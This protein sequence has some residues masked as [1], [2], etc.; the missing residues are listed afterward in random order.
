[1][2][3]SPSSRKGPV[4]KNSGRESSQKLVLPWKILVPTMNSVA[5]QTKAAKQTLNMLT[6]VPTIMP[7][8]EIAPLRNSVKRVN[9]IP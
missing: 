1:M 7:Y 5:A 2:E 9:P 4:E 3:I 6:R 8:G